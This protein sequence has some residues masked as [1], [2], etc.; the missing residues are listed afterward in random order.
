RI[1]RGTA[2]TKERLAYRTES[3]AVR[4]RRVSEALLRKPSTSHAG[5]ARKASSAT[6]ART[7]VCPRVARS[8][9]EGS[10]RH[11]HARNAGPEA[12][13]DP[14]APTPI[15]N[16]NASPDGLARRIQR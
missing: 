10:A 6:K 12:V 3:K 9:G 8:L 7:S 5:M 4:K 13:S 15:R 1:T 11:R 14:N 2:R 16:P